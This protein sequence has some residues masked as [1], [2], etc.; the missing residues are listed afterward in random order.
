MSQMISLKIDGESILVPAGTTVMDAAEQIGIHIP[1][2]CYHPDLSLEGNCRVCVVAVE[3]FD[4]GLASCATTAWEGMEVQTNSPMIRQ[5][6]R[7]IVE[8]LLDN[9][10]K[11]CQTCD[12]DGNCELQNLSYRMGVRERLFEGK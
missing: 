4:H 1:R 7:D 12:R 11:D 8:L 2:L 3:G 10:P 5:A 9:H 6:R